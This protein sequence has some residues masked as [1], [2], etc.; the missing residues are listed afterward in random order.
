MKYLLQLVL[1]LSAHP[2]QKAIFFGQNVTA[3]GTCVVPSS[4]EVSQW[5]HYGTGVTCAGGCTVGN[6]ITLVPDTVG[7]NNFAGNT[8]IEAEPTYQPAIFGV[9]PAGDYPAGPN[10]LFATSSIPTS[11]PGNATYAFWITVKTGT[12]GGSLGMIGGNSGALEWRINSSGHQEILISGFASIGTGSATL[13]SNTKY[14]LA[15]SINGTTGV[16]TLWKIASNSVTVDGTGTYG[17]LPVGFSNSVDEIGA[18]DGGSE[19]FN[20]LI[21]D[22]GYSTSSWT[23]TP[24]SLI[25]AF[26]QCNAGV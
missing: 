24:L 18:A 20:G 26:S 15:M 21:L 19:P 9:L 17:T 25:A 13:S 1:V 16:W 11:S 10:A 8:G 7:S 22:A 4:V 3:S 14:T 12:V 6:A 23:A 2:M 5:P